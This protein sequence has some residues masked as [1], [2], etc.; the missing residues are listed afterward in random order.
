MLSQNF[1]RVEVNDKITQEKVSLPGL[2][3]H[4][5]QHCPSG[6]MRFSFGRHLIFGH[7]V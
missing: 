2:S 7:W 3:I 4:L 6:T 1:I 5:A